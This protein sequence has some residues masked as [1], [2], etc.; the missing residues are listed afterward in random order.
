MGPR[1]CPGTCSSKR[2]PQH[3]AAPSPTALFLAL[4]QLLLPRVLHPSHTQM[5]PPPCLMLLRG[6]RPPL[7]QGRE[8]S[9]P[10]AT[11][12]R[13]GGQMGSTSAGDTVS[14]GPPAGQ[15]LRLQHQHEAIWSARSPRLCLRGEPDAAH[16]QPLR[17]TLWPGVSGDLGSAK[18]FTPWNQEARWPRAASLLLRPQDAPHLKATG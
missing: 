15:A 6:R 7:H 13:A 3:Q 18:G 5:L 14:R 11:R 2:W 12:A 8:A 4:N 1:S 10:A 17:Q 9:L 16:P